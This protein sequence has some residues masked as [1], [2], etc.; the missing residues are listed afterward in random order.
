MHASHLTWPITALESASDVHSGVSRPLQGY[1]SQKIHLH[2]VP[3]EAAATARKAN[4]RNF[5]KFMM[6]GG[7]RGAGSTVVQ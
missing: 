7:R 3:E 4:G 1:D 5:M 2:V 6:A